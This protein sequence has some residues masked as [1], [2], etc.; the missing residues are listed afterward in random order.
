VQGNSATGNRVQGNFIGTDATGTLDLGNVRAGVLVTSSVVG[1][2]S[3]TTISGNLIAANEVGVF[4]DNSPDNTIGGTTAEERNVI[5]GN[6]VDGVGLVGGG[7]VR[8]LVQGNFIGTD[9]TGSRAQGN[10]RSGVRITFFI[11]STDSAAH[12]TIGGTAA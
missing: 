8:N 2:A 12:N 10:G 3:R 9:L 4:I 5:S 1:L 6:G 11:G 7:A